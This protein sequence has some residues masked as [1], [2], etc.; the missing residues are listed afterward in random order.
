MI[1]PNEFSLLRRAGWIFLI[2]LA[3]GLLVALS[4]VGI[5]P[6]IAYWNEVGIPLL[7]A[8]VLAALVLALG[9]EVGWRA[10]R[11]PRDQRWF[12]WLLPLF[13][14]LLAAGIWLAEPMRHTYSHPRPSPPY[15][16][17]YPMRDSSFYDLSA[18]YVLIGQGINNDQ[19][20]EKPVYM[21][22]L[23]LLHALG[24]QSIYV[25][26]G[27]QVLV[28]AWF[29]VFLYFLGRR[30]HHRSTGVF[31][32]GLGIFKE[33]NAIAASVDVQTVH[34]KMLLTESLTALLLAIVVWWA[35][36]WLQGHRRPVSDVVWLGGLLGVAFLLRTNALI[37]L[38]L[39]VGVL[40]IVGRKIERRR[41]TVFLLI[42]FL[43]FVSPWMT[44][45]RDEQGRTALQLKIEGVLDRYRFQREEPGSS[46]GPARRVQEISLGGRSSKAAL[47][48]RSVAAPDSLSIDSAL[49]F[50]PAHFLHNQIGALFVLPVSLRI[51]SLKKMVDQ[52]LWELTWAG[53]LSVENA[54]LLFF[55][56]GV[57]S[58][59]L[60]SAWQRWKIVGLIPAL[61][62]IVYYLSNALARTSGA[63][64]LVPVDWVVYFY[65]GLG[66]FQALEMMLKRT[67]LGPL[68]QT[69]LEQELGA[70]HQDERRFAW[71]K[72]AGIFLVIGGTMALLGWLPDRYP[73]LTRPEAFRAVQE[74]APAWQLGWSSREFLQFRAQPEAVVLRGRLLYPRSLAANKGL[75]SRCSVFDAAFGDR[76]YARLSFIVLGPISAGVVVAPLEDVRAEIRRV[77]LAAGPDVWVIGCREQVDVVGAQRGFYPLVR[78]LAVIVEHD[79][80][81]PTILKPADQPLTCQSSD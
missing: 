64:Y 17:Y 2:F 20:T 49:H 9:V 58:L 41:T 11:R 51:H 7:A 47:S 18:Q 8:Q 15:Y 74:R 72:P 16:E 5:T 52:P 50:V 65:F 67:R 25:V 53:E 38:L 30:L 77:N 19:L 31:V 23:A 34:V 46:Q 40:W 32:A 56:L 14:W 76:S 73:R 36:R 78:A 29:P 66:V 33:R 26:S 80:Q 27:L 4:R 3:I 6:D 71:L 37:L 75:C 12:E 68:S 81:R 1:E 44:L 22:F 48:M 62:E 28:L 39:F 69:A 60:A 45:N 21:F 63:R 13:L 61:V 57:L 55:N 54:L 70:G 10:L 24:G 35:V 42:G 43:A 79:D 59:G